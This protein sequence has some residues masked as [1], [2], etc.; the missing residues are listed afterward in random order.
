MAVGPMA[1]TFRGS[2]EVSTN[3]ETLSG[4]VIGKGKDRLSRSIL[5]GCLD[6]S[7][8]ANDNG[9]SSINLN[10]L[11]RLSGPLSQFGRPAIVEEIADQLL[12]QIGLSL[13][14][15]ATGKTTASSSHNSVG[16]ISILLKSLLNILKKRFDRK[17]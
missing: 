12:K 9:G 15:A 16:G 2:A 8:S 17:L 1:A 14:E 11:Y 10:M 13:V 7:V 5:E 3:D 6:Y 4:N